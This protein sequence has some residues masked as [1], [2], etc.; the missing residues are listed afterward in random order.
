MWFIILGKGDEDGFCR[1]KQSL[2]SLG[3]LETVL[4]ANN[5]EL[6]FPFSSKISRAE[7]SLK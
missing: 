6:V 4:A 7:Q 3:N 1:K 2:S 5:F